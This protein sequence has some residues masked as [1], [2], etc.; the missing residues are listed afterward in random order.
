[1]MS[2]SSF[3]AG[4]GHHTAEEAALAHGVFGFNSQ[5]GDFGRLCGGWEGSVDPPCMPLLHKPCGG[6]K[7]TK[8]T[9]AL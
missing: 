3:A 4:K 8:G 1:M 2:V 5:K 6:I 9:Q 7:R